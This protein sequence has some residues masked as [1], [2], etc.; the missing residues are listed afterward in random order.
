M[1]VIRC[2]CCVFL[3]WFY[4]KLFFIKNRL[5]FSLLCV[6]VGSMYCSFISFDIWQLI[7]FCFFFL[8]WFLVFLLKMFKKRIHLEMK[9]V[10]WLQ[11]MN[12]K[13]FAI[14]TYRMTT[15]LICRIKFAENEFLKE[16]SSPPLEQNQNYQTSFPFDLPRLKGLHF[17]KW[18]TKKHPLE[19]NFNSQTICVCVCVLKKSNKTSDPMSFLTHNYIFIRG[20]FLFVWF[21][22]GNFFLFVADINNWN[23]MKAELSCS[24]KKCVQRWMER[25]ARAVG[26]I[27]LKRSYAYLWD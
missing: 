24:V 22:L 3:F 15:V 4:E 13:K 2:D 18:S 8:N 21:C 7:I 6:C 5:F 12:Q 11:Y 27:A 1:C 20:S 19:V 9:S 25:P 16:Q 14:W 23:K 10:V 26:N 17:P